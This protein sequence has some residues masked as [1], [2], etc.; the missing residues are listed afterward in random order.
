MSPG[1]HRSPGAAGAV[2][3]LT[4]FTAVLSSPWKVQRQTFIFVCLFAFFDILFFVFSESNRAQFD[5]SGKI[6]PFTA[7]LVES[8]D[9]S[10]SLD[11]WKKW[12]ERKSNHLSIFNTHVCWSLVERTCAGTWRVCR[13]HTERPGIKLTTFS[14][15][16]SSTNRSITEENTKGKNKRELFLCQATKCTSTK[17]FEPH[18]Q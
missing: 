15:W 10:S 18:T 1:W 8:W 17:T 2:R 16:G 4:G 11:V 9:A 14:L 6:W 3:N 5:L 12:T 7:K 13:L